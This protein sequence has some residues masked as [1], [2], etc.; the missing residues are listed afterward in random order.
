[1]ISFAVFGINRLINKY[2]SCKLIKYFHL[3]AL[4]FWIDICSN[5]LIQMFAKFANGAFKKFD[6]I[7][8]S[9]EVCNFKR[10]TSLDYYYLLVIKL[11]I[12]PKITTKYNNYL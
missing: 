12:N 4:I 3:Y 8:I 7:I 10:C 5:I 9:M 11:L 1:M 6:A 2:Q